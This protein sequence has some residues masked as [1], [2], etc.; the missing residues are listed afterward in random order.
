MAMQRRTVI[1]KFKEHRPE[2]IA[3]FDPCLKLLENNYDYDVV[4]SYM[5][6]KLENAHREILYYGIVVLHDVSTKLAFKAIDTH[7]LTRKDFKEKFSHVYGFNIPSSLSKKIK[8]AE[9]VRDR[10]LHGKSPETGKRAQSIL[11]VLYYFDGLDCKVYDKVNIWIA[12]DRRGIKG[13]K[14]PLSDATSRWVLIGMGFSL[15]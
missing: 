5:F 4:V 12:G 9:D 1:K 13:A 8:S 3:Y 2:V 11:D 14:A 7:D 10:I 6:S 15:S